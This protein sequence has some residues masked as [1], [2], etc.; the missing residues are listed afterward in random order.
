MQIKK[1]EYGVELE[2]ETPYEQE[3]LKHLHRQGRVTMKFDDDWDNTGNLTIE[4]KPHPW[5]V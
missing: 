2:A 1:T 4:G 3:C 5:D